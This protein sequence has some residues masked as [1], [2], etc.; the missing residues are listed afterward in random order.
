MAAEKSAGNY[1]AGALGEASAPRSV[2]KKTEDFKQCDAEGFPDDVIMYM[3]TFGSGFCVAQAVSE[4]GENAFPGTIGVGIGRS[5][6]IR[7]RNACMGL[8][9]ECVTSKS[10]RNDIGLIIIT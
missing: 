7:R 2:T 1:W 8:R 6:E 4:S 3:K 10:W 9:W 5:V